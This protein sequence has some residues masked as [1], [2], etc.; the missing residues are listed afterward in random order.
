MVK[1][2]QKDLGEPVVVYVPLSQVSAHIAGSQ[3]SVSRFKGM[4]RWSKSNTFVLPN[5]EST[6]SGARERWSLGLQNLGN[7]C[8]LNSVLQCLTYTLLFAFLPFSHTLLSLLLVFNLRVLALVFAI[9]RLIYVLRKEP[10][11]QTGF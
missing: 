11:R 8:Y 10:M 2:Y 9:R 3:V 5:A 6:Q 4:Q 1:A 7:T